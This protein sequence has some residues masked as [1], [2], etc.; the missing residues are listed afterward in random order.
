[1]SPVILVSFYP[2]LIKVYEVLFLSLVF[3]LTSS[4]EVSHWP[5]KKLTS[6]SFTSPV[7]LVSFYPQ[8]VK[9]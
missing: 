6:S 5:W 1:M 4:R 3:M 7:I 2:Q 9:F 8:F